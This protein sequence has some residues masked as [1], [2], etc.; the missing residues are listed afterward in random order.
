MENFNFTSL[1]D[2]QALADT[3]ADISASKISVQ[4]A[5]SA[6]VAGIADQALDV[7]ARLGEGQ[8]AVIPHS[9]PDEFQAAIM[10]SCLE[11]KKRADAARGLVDT[12]LKRACV[13]AQLPCVISL[14]Y[15]RV[16]KDGIVTQQ[17]GFRVK[18]AKPAEV[19]TDEIANVAAL[20][21]AMCANADHAKSAISFVKKEDVLLNLKT[22]YQTLGVRAIED[23]EMIEEMTEEAVE[24]FLSGVETIGS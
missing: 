2:I 19:V 10:V 17:P 12:P 20:L 4:D 18:T 1:D 11:S 9:F 16:N 14:A 22:L 15:R 7:W 23:E 6:L 5:M 8:E 24:A 21:L 13:K 3:L